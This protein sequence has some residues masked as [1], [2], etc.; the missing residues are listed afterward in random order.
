MP[1]RAWGFKSPSG[2]SL[3]Q[4]R[5]RPRSHDRGLRRRTPTISFT[6]PTRPTCLR[7]P[8][9]PLR[10][11]VR[12]SPHGFAGH[13]PRAHTA[14]RELTREPRTR[15]AAPAAAV[16]ACELAGRWTGAPVR[17]RWS[18]DGFAGHGPRTHTASRELT[19]D[20]RTQ[21]GATRL[22]RQPPALVRE[23]RR[24]PGGQFAGGCGGSRALGRELGSGAANW[25]MG[26]RAGDGGDHPGSAGGVGWGAG[27]W[28]RR[29]RDPV[30]HLRHRA[31][32]ALRTREPA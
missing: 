20:P 17:V 5:R 30:R 27:C 18:V 4:R 15:G 24:L 21:S 22:R 1:A 28:G 10:R 9:H 11:R 32:P 3:R 19:Q 25:G 26:S 2:H 31:R 23:P 6:A 12:G 13:G 8:H 7:T 29:R 16:L 14:S